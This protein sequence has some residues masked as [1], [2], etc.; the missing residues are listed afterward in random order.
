MH[1]IHCTVTDEEEDITIEAELF[2]DA[3][4]VRQWD[5]H[6]VFFLV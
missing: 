2:I 6:A 5:S 4:E 3:K 1:A